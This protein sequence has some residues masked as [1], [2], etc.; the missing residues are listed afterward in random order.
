MKKNILITG[1][2][3]SGKSTLLKKIIS[4]QGNKVGF[5]TK[6]VLGNIVRVGFE[7]ETQSGDKSMLASVHFQTKQKVGRYFVNMSN[8]GAI[9]AKVTEFDNQDLLFIDE[10]AEMQLFS[11]KFKDLVLAYF[12]SKN[13]CIAT[14]SKIY[15][16]DFIKQI[17]ERDDIILIEIS[18]ENR[19]YKL[20]YIQALL[21]KIA[22]ARR[23]ASELERFSFS[24]NQVIMKTDHGM[25][26]LSKQN[27]GWVCDCEFFKE[28]LRENQLCSHI[29]AAE[30]VN[31][32]AI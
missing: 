26:S 11:E 32:L 5:F 13:D 30:E 28:Y 3:R 9:I 2:P 15:S 18:E 8:I 19:D 27:N 22:K 16:D 6:E 17:K 14:L 10:I 31:H 12:N 23:Y 24:P 1:L 21:V 25:R 7:M 4:V 29:M 20:V